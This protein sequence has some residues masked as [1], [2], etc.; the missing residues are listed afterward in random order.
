MDNKITLAKGITI[1]KLIPV[2]TAVLM[3]DCHRASDF[4]SFNLFEQY[5]FQV[6][7]LLGL[8]SEHEK[9][10]VDHED[11]GFYIPTNNLSAIKYA[12]D[13]S[14]LCEYRTR[15]DAVFEY[16]ETQGIDLDVDLFEAIDL[17]D[18]SIQQLSD[19]K[20]YLVIK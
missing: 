20:F 4:I 8:L 1:P 11:D 5:L 15:Q 16:L 18:A 10:D 19:D 14:F 2:E 6:T 9:E 17:L 13:N 3:V 7:R 12:Y